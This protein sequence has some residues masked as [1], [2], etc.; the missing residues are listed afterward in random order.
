M[1]KR[2][3]GVVETFNGEISALRRDGYSLQSIGDVIGV[4]RKRV[5]QILNEYYSGTA[6]PL[7]AESQV[8]KLCGCSYM[9]IRKLQSRE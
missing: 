2:G 1:G 8:A 3:T 4:T 6:I 7:L 9:T 5:R